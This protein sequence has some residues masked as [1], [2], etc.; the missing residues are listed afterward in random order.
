VFSVAVHPTALFPL[1]ETNF[2]IGDATRAAGPFGEANFF[3]LSMAALVPLAGHLVLRGGG[4]AGAGAVAAPLLLAGVLAT[5]SRGAAIA[6]LVG[7]LFFAIV[8]GSRA[9]RWCVAGLIVCGLA[10]LPLFGGQAHTSRNRA[11]GG[12]LTENRIALAMF[13]DH[14]VFGVGPNQYREL[15]S[16]YSR[17]LGDDPRPVREAHSLPL[18]IAAEQGVLGLLGWLAAGIAVAL[19]ALRSHVWRE[20]IARALVAALISYGVGS[21][22]LHGSQL[23]LPFLLAGLLLATCIGRRP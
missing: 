23:R 20:P 17:R 8:S 11:V 3:A 13:A 4:R 14:P 15:Y 19:A 18:E 2:A 1:N 10:L 21:L 7:S 16:G 5:G 9:A 6:A 22:F 12:R